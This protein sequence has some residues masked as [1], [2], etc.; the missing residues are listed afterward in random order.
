MKQGRLAELQYQYK[1]WGRSPPR[2]PARQSAA[3]K[4]FPNLRSD[5]E[6]KAGTITRREPQPAPKSA[7]GRLWPGLARGRR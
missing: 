5:S 1:N 6:W 3:Q 4:I 7:A 2:E